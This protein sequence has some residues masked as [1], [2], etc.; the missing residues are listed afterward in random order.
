MSALPVEV[1]LHCMF[2]EISE[3]PVDVST[4]VKHINV[5]DVVTVPVCYYDRKINK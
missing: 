5:Y 4:Q 1:L 3:R 2:Y